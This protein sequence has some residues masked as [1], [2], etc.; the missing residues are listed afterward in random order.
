MGTDNKMYYADALRRM[1][2]AGTNNITVM[3]QEEVP[4]MKTDLQLQHAVQTELEWDPM[5]DPA[6]IGEP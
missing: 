6:E 2:E 1:C 3:C 5:V 4:A